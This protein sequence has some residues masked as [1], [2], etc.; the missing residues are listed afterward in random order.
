M[1]EIVITTLAERP[2]I[3]DGHDHAV[4]VEPNV[5]VRHDLGQ[6]PN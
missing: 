3:V 5:W 2:D 6:N 1:S 4:Y